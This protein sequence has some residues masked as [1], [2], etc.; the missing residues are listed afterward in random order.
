MDFD[1]VKRAA[2]VVAVI[3]S[4][5]VALKREGRD[6]VGLCPFHADKKP[7]LRVTPGKGLWRCMSCDAAGNVIQFVA[8][9]EG[10]E[11]K[12][13]ALRLLATLPGVQRASQLENK[14]TSSPVVPP[15]VAADLL[16]RVAGFYA[17]T[18]HKD[19]A[20]AEKRGRKKGPGFTYYP[21][22]PLLHS[23]L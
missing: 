19:R 23:C 11:E 4:H 16:A 9:K 14:K 12:E 2:D 6:Y 18:L 22:A 20:G 21:I 13:A 3:Q 7:S 17:R 1:E 10:I 8:R 5:G 15:A